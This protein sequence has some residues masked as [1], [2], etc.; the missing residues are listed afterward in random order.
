MLNGAISNAVESTLE[1][2]SGK[3]QDD[4]NY[5]PTG[6]LKT[7]AIRNYGICNIINADIEGVTANGSVGTMNIYDGNFGVKIKGS[8]SNFNNGTMNIYNANIGNETRGSINN[9]ANLNIYNCKYCYQ[10]TGNSGTTHLYGG[11]IGV[12]QYNNVIMEGGTVKYIYQPKTVDIKGGTLTGRNNVA[13]LLWQG[14]ANISGGIFE[15][16]AF[17]GAGTWNVTG[18]KFKLKPSTA[19]ISEGYK[20]VGPDE[21]GYYEVVKE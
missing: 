13:L 19:R 16:N 17:D 6:G 14:T 2:N 3:Y 7:Y 4:V 5:V 8:L 18:G 9:T 10:I 21:N 15:A 12:I 20:C 11:K 1:I